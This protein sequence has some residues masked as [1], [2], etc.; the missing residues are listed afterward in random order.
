MNLNRIQLDTL[1]EDKLLMYQISKLNIFIK[2]F[3]KVH[4]CAQRT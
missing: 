3:L 4:T 1:I 2:D